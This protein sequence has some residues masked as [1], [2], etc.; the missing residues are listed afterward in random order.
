MSIQDK[1]LVKCALEIAF[2]DSR[3][4]FVAWFED[5][6]LGLKADA[7]IKLF[8][9]S[10]ANTRPNPQQQKDVAQFHAFEAR[11]SYAQDSVTGGSSQGL[12]YDTAFASC[13][14]PQ[15]HQVESDLLH[16]HTESN[17]YI[18][19]LPPNK[20]IL[21]QTRL[22]YGR[23]SYRPED[24]EYWKPNFAI[25]DYMERDLLC[26]HSKKSGAYLLI[27]LEENGRLTCQ[28]TDKK[29]KE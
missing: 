20:I 6:E 11:Q 4:L 19:V 12:Y 9:S 3:K 13:S 28:V 8:A 18:R 22:Y 2:N 26:R 10:I 24:V 29:G 17:D 21:L 27:F 7:L 23:I 15:D 1:G 16:P 14:Q 25:P 5:G